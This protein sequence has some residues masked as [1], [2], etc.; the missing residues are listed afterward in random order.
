MEIETDNTHSVFSPLA[1]GAIHDLQ[2]QT[3]ICQL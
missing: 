1:L 2:T 3:V